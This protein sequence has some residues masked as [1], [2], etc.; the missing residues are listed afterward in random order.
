MLVAGMHDTQLAVKYTVRGGNHGSCAVFHN[1][2]AVKGYTSHKYSQA[3]RLK[4]PS[5]GGFHC[6]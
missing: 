5:G 1:C 2:L 6:N 4:V 3:G